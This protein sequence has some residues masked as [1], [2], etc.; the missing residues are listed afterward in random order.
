MG[1]FKN[2]L[3]GLLTGAGVAMEKQATLQAQERRDEILE[4]REM[5]LAKYRSDI[6]TQ[7][8]KDLSDYTTANDMTKT[9]MELGIRGNLAAA[10]DER[11]GVLEAEKD[12][13]EFTNWTKKNQIEFKQDLTRDAK[14]HGFKLSEQANAAALETAQQAARDGTN[15]TRWETNAEDGTLIG[16]TA[17]G[18]IYR[19][20]VVPTPKGKGDEGSLM[21]QYGDTP[22]PAPKRG[23]V[24]KPAAP[25]AKAAPTADPAKVI[26]KQEWTNAYT[27]ALRKK[28]NGD[29]RFKN[30]SASQIKAKVDDMLT[31][32]GYVAR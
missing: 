22:A 15:I 24:E 19:S 26:S 31:S 6:D 13:R 14:Q 7:A 28:E 9:E 25:A 32:Q 29:P 1:T 3:G 4:R 10:D 11:R 20:N 27:E 2:V 23:L 5:A 17:T 30:L 21:D 8:R 12:K 16:V 18:K